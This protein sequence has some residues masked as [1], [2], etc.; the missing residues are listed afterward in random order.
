MHGAT[1][2]ITGYRSLA[3]HHQWGRVVGDVN[4]LSSETTT[5]V[6]I[7]VLTTDEGLEGVGIGAHRDID[8]LMPVIEG[9]DP[10]AVVHLYDQMLAATFKLGHI[11]AVFGTLGTVDLALWDLKAKMADEPLWR[12]LG[13][14]DRFVPAYAS[15][16]DFGLTDEDLVRVHERFAERGFT[17]AKLKGG[18]HIQDDLRRLGLLRDVFSRNT[19]APG[20]MFDANESLHRSQAVRHLNQLEQCFDLTWVEEPVRRWDVRGHA[21]IRQHIRAGVASGENLTGLEQLRGL[22]DGDAIDIAQVGSG[23]G[24]THLLRAG[25]LAHGYDLPLSPVGYTAT[26]AAAAGVLPNFLVTEVQDLAHPVGVWVDQQIDDGGIVLGDQPGSG[27][28]IDE[29]AL[30]L[31]PEPGWTAHSGPHTRPLR[32]GLRMVPE[33]DGGAPRGPEADSGSPGRPARWGKT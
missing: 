15:A 12:H 6:D 21:S 20:L 4:G 31:P 30:R 1:M 22:I 26:V 3:T 11:G 23:W 8:R 18:R 14:G 33:D 9:A 7:L 27:F 29:S 32:A 16:L 28:T 5:R 17:S 24:I 10:R 25:H 19:S 13:G 2:K